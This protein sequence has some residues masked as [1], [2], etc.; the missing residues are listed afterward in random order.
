MTP[1]HLRRSATARFLIGIAI[2]SGAHPV[3]PAAA[4][5]G[6]LTGRILIATPELS[7][8][9]FARTVIYLVRHGKGGALGLVVNEPMGE[10]PLKRL[11]GANGAKLEAAANP[12]TVHYGGPVEPRQAFVLQSAGNISKGSAKAGDKIL[13][14]EAGAALESLTTDGRP[15]HL[16]LA[17]GYSGWAPGQL[18]LLDEVSKKHRTN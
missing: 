9:N 12:V 11:L 16:V 7:D 2:L 14:S 5:D 13:F 18:E 10:V 15:R 8:T 17:L 4:Q 3:P 1:P 6:E